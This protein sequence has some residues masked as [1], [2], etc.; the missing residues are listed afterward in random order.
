MDY[1]EPPVYIFL[2]GVFHP[3]PDL[4][5]P[6]DNAHVIAVDGGAVH[7]LCLGWPIHLL[8]GDFDSLNNELLDLIVKRNPNIDIRRFNRDKDES[9]FELALRIIDPQNLGRRQ[10]I[11]LGG[12]GGRWDMTIANL[13]LPLAANFK[14]LHRL[15]RPEIVFRDGAWDMYLLNGPSQLILKPSVGVRRVSLLPLREK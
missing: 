6:K 1:D 7:C 9:D 14:L 11:I 15:P 8:L 5:F 2:N 13:L 10:V 4:I 3:P 12:L